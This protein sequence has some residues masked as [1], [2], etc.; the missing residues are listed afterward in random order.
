M[1]NGAA[2]KD[3]S[4]RGGQKQQRRTGAAEEEW[5]SMERQEQQGRTGAAGEDRSSRGGME[6]HGKTRAAGEDRSSRGGME[7]HGKTRAAGEDRSSRGGQEQQRRTGAAE[8]DRSSKG[9]QEQQGR[10]GEAGLDV[11][12]GISDVRNNPTVGGL[13][14]R[15]PRNLLLGKSSDGE[16]EKN[17]GVLHK[18]DKKWSMSVLLCLL[19]CGKNSRNTTHLVS[20]I[21]LNFPCR[22]KFYGQ[23]NF[24]QGY[25]G[26]NL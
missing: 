10:K 14:I 24:N 5:S 4:S 25:F 16:N 13:E 20:T 12:E 9:G 1:S 11:R 18:G 17:Y 6:Q 8:E 22:F 23:K 15:R 7:Q 26:L 2:W 3:K 19:A 21:S